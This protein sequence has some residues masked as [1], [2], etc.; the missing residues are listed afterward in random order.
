M[1][2]YTLEKYFLSSI[3][4]YKH[5]KVI[6]A[7]SGGIDSVVMC[8]LFAQH[9]LSF[10]IAH[11]NFLLR[12]KDAHEDALFVKN[13]AK[14]YCVPFFYQEYDTQIYAQEQKMSIQMAARQLRY[15][16]FPSLIQ[17]YCYSKIAT[18]HHI[19]D[20]LETVLLNFTKGTGIAGLHGIVS[21]HQYIRPLFWATKQHI[22]DYAQKYKL[23]W[24]EDHSN[25]QQ[26][27]KRNFIR[28]KIIPQLK[29]INPNLEYTFKNTL[30]R[31]KDVED[32][33]KQKVDDTKKQ[34]LQQ[35]DGTYHFFW[36]QFKHEL[37]A[38]TIAHEIMKSFSFSYA[39]IKNV[40]TTPHHVGKKWIS[41]THILWMDRVSWVITTQQLSNKKFEI[42]ITKEQK[43]IQYA[44]Q[45]WSTKTI[46]VNEVNFAQ[47]KTFFFDFD[48]LTFPL[49]L[50]YWQP[51][52]YFYPL[53]MQQKK[54]ISDFLIDKKVP[55][56]KKKDILVITNQKKHVIAIMDFRIDD[57]YKVTAKT[58]NVY[59]I[60]P[61]L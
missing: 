54:K 33:F 29:K 22:D 2:N 26:K 43:I 20:S 36:N 44:L 10:C 17:K 30:S 52:D 27:Y 15:Q 45:V 49:I 60:Q 40:C 5:Q 55:L 12:G 16:W 28:H 31:I 1:N 46:E 42:F 50:R 18:A 59:M 41:A 57:R 25:K 8:H 13:L 23:S 35:K 61:A 56:Y 6:L 21:T 58:C 47:K 39:Q 9:A 51:G 24:R 19:N 37:G 4:S 32:I 34:Y 3:S 7:V 11:V 38:Q 53:G 48:K 14:E